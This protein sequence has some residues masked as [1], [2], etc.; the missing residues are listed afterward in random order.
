MKNLLYKE[1]TLSIHPFFSLIMPF[2][3][4]LLFLIPNWIFTIVF[5]YFFWISAPQI[6]S[7]YIAQLDQAFLSSLPVS[8]KSIAYSKVLSFIVLEL[9]HLGFGGIVAAIHI[10]LYGKGNFV[11]DVNPAFF[12]AVLIIYASFNIVFFPWYF[13][14]AYRYGLPLIFAVIVSLLTAA[15]FELGT[16]LLPWLGRLMKS[17]SVSM[18]LGILLAGVAIFIG[19]NLIA[20]RWSYRNY[21]RIR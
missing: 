4:S 21:M 17:D 19:A 16:V 9:M 12:G 18:Q 10:M 14:T 2:M 15:F 7:G 8:K 3:L 13:R 1:L 6:F 5:L 20:A 11:M